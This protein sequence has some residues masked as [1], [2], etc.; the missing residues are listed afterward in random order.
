MAHLDHR[1]VIA[2]KREVELFL[3]EIG[4]GHLDAHGVAQLVLVVATTP[5]EAEVALV[6]LV[7]VVVQVAH[8]YHAFAV[9]LVYL[10]I[11]AIG[12]D[13]AD[14][15]VELLAQVVAHK[16]HHLV[17]DESRSAFCATSSM[18]EQCSQSSS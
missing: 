15:G 10:G 9:V 14:V 11:D 5:H 6:K 4:L 13:A 18:S 7:V 8:G 1:L 16:F 17:L 2:D 12:C 3:F